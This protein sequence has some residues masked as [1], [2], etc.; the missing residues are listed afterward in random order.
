[1]PRYTK[2]NPDG[3]KHMTWDAGIVVKEFDPETGEINLKDI[4]WETNGD[5]SFSATRDLDDMGAEINNCPENTKQLQKAK[6]WQATVS[7]TA[8]SVTPETVAELLGNADVSDI[9]DAI[10]KITP[11]N[12]LLDSDFQDAWLI[13][14]YSEFNG[15][16]NGGYLAIHLIN[17]FSSDGLS[18]SFGKDASGK[19]AYTLKAF[20]DMEDMDA[21]PF[22]IYMM[23]GAAESGG[24][25]AE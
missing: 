21:V 7:G 13:V 17:A 4:Q 10:K 16:T 22:E 1:M 19:F 8:V 18:G 2:M 15:E 11:R 5:N 25:A 6:P 24:G 23:H 12:E 3:F 14:N 9:S 20:Y